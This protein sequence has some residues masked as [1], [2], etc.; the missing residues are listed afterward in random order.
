MPTER[1]LTT[2]G[3]E[4]M[5]TERIL[6]TRSMDEIKKLTMEEVYVSPFTARRS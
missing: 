1:R 4:I 6:T 2:S 5:P 3:T